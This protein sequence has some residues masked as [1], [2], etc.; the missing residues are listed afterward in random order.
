MRDLFVPPPAPT[1]VARSNSRPDSV[2]SSGSVRAVTP[3]DPYGYPQERQQREQSYH[4]LK[5]SLRQNERL[6]QSSYSTAPPSRQ[7]SNTSSATTGVSGS[8]NWETY[9][10]IS[11]PEEDASEDYYAKLR[12]AR[13][14]RFT[15]ED[16]HIPQHGGPPKK[17]KGI[18][19]HG[20]PAG[21]VFY[22]ARGNRI[23]SGSEANWTDE[24]AF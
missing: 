13:V 2:L 9:S 6:T 7:I 16:G 19:Q 11:E 1:P 4:E 10:E 15:P 21:H 24:D 14:K 12:A 22:D 8:E 18:P 5:A 3:E 17:Q 23:I 20:A